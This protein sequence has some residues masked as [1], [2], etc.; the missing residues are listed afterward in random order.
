ME[1]KVKRKRRFAEIDK[2]NNNE[3]FYKIKKNEQR[4]EMHLE[5]LNSTRDE[6]MLEFILERLNEK[7][8]SEEV[9]DWIIRWEFISFR[10]KEKSSKDN[11]YEFT[12]ELTL[13]VY[14]QNVTRSI[15]RTC[16]YQRS[17]DSAS[18]KNCLLLCGKTLNR[19]S[20][21]GLLEEIGW[22]S[23]LKGETLLTLIKDVT[24]LVREYISGLENVDDYYKDVLHDIFDEKI[25]EEMIKEV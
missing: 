7:Q 14:D 5:E 20:V 8:Y 12:W 18:T 11:S 25:W 17:D 19:K 2:L 22:D 16:T 6:R 24:L 13:G 9:F 3:I 10:K 15:N 4:I 21:N 23:I 1:N